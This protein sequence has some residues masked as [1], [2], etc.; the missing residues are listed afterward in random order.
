VRARADGYSIMD[1][2]YEVGFRSLSVPISD[3]AGTTVAALN[4]CC[5]SP[6][7]SLERMHD[8]FLPAALRAAAAITDSLPADYFGSGA[9]AR[10][11]AA[12]VAPRSRRLS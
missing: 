3:R 8:A 9:A 4:V 2:E 10:R 6:R 7:V 1:E 5:P 11:T 12:G